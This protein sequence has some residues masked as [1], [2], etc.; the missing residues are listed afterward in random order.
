MVVHENDSNPEKS[1]RTE[2]LIVE[3]VEW[4]AVINNP[5]HRDGESLK[6]AYYTAPQSGPVKHG[7]IY[8]GVHR[9]YEGEADG[10][11]N[12]WHQIALLH[13]PEYEFSNNQYL[14][15]VVIDKGRLHVGDESSSQYA[16]DAADQFMEWLATTEL[17]LHHRNDV[18]L[19]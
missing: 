11:Y 1:Q 8:V 17:T 14:M 15:N 4:L 6:Y 19:Y 13:P 12:D 16:R 5:D 2:D 10:E 18:R 3:V 9:S 7:G